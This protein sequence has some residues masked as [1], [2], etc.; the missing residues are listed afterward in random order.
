MW[1]IIRSGIVI[2][3]VLAF[4]QVAHGQSFSFYPYDQD[5]DDS[6]TDVEIENW[7]NRA[8][9]LCDSRLSDTSLNLRIVDSYGSYTTDE[10]HLYL[11]DDCDSDSM[12]ITEHCYDERSPTQFE[13]K[14]GKKV[15]GKENTRL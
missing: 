12:A 5:N 4:P 1:N 2:G 6:L 10:V 8:R 11:G 13:N 15:S 9:C 14:S 7:V 3:A